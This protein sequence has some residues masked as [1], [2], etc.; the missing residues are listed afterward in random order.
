M[1]DSVNAT[2]EGQIFSDKIYK[3]INEITILIE[4][5][6]T[7]GNH[8]EF[9]KIIDGLSKTELTDIMQT[10]QFELLD[11]FVKKIDD[12]LSPDVLPG[13]DE[14]RTNLVYNVIGIKKFA[15][16]INRFDD[17]KFYD[18]LHHHQ[19]LKEYEHY[20][21]LHKNLDK[22]K[23][24]ILEDFFK[25]PHSSAARLM[26]KNFTFLSQTLTIKEI[27]NNLYS[28]YLSDDVDGILLIDDM[29]QVVGM[30]ALS[31][32]LKTD[33]D[34]VASSV[35][36]EYFIVVNTTTTQKK[37]ARLFQ[38]YSLSCALVAD[39]NNSICGIITIHDITDAVEDQADEDLFHLQY[40][41]NPEA[42]ESKNLLKSVSARVPWLFVNVIFS[43]LVS[44]FISLFTDVI[45]KHI[46]LAVLIPI[47]ASISS[48]S[49]AQTIATTI[50][51]LAKQDVD[52]S[53]MFKIFTHEIL[54]AIFVA[55]CMAS[56]SC[57][58]VYWRF[59]HHMAFVYFIAM[60]FA[61]IIASLSGIFI[62]L[63]TN[64]IKLDP[65]II[66]PI[67]VTTISD[68]CSYLLALMLAI[69]L[70]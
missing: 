67:L 18:F 31:K 17:H 38:R 47:I 27:K 39:K 63:I 58:V 12:Y 40:I 66:S 57:V 30:L 46:A 55:T 6:I 41:S 69:W 62:P 26:Q 14:A 36:N 8:K 51:N 10:I 24:I 54:T 2:S 22:D 60:L 3:E 25:Y 34:A 5:Y 52:R 29:S 7:I 20:E 45:E 21:K 48:I 1:L 23:Q 35:M 53:N 16:L 42:A 68:F 49:G 59:G 15:D 11:K 64:W 44:G 61:F 37:V 19:D 32:I 56:V 43:M 33:N 70:L 4:K 50:H 9:I 28:K 65:A 13:L